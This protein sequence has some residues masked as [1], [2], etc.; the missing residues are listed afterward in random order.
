LEFARPFVAANLYQTFHFH[1]VIVL[2]FSFPL[3]SL[4]RIFLLIFGFFMRKVEGNNKNC[5]LYLAFVCWFSFILFEICSS[6][7]HFFSKQ[8]LKHFFPSFDWLINANEKFFSTFDVPLSI[9]Y[10]CWLSKWQSHCL[11]WNS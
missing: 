2:S 5:E 10:T 4:T 7:L 9:L 8:F 3:N 6:T 1:I 11:F